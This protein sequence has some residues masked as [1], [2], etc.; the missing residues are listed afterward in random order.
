MILQLAAVYGH[1][2]KVSQ[3]LSWSRTHWLWVKSHCKSSAM[4][5]RSVQTFHLN[6]VSCFQ[7]FFCVCSLPHHVWP[8]SRKCWAH[9]KWSATRYSEMERNLGNLDFLHELGDKLQQTSIVTLLH[10]DFVLNLIVFGYCSVPKKIHWDTLDM[11]GLHFHYPISICISFLLHLE[12]SENLL[13]YGRW[14]Q[15]SQ[16][17]LALVTSA[18][19]L[20]PWISLA[21]LHV[22]SSFGL[23][24]CNLCRSGQQLLG[25]Q[26]SWH[27]CQQ[28]SP[29]LHWRRGGESGRE[30]VLG[31][32]G[33][34]L[35]NA[36]D[37]L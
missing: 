32:F 20:D 25:N 14:H 18:R 7:A 37:S 34:W 15:G 8:L 21:F 11:I 10:Y 17:S 23:A 31:R 22:S 19:R 35:W 2:H 16:C 4:L 26:K 36:I 1:V 6:T 12:H 9:I 27:C 29:P 28:I 30:D 24:F 3:P 5:I 33:S 13:A